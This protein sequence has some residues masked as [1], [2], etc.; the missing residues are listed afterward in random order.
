[1]DPIYEAMYSDETFFEDW[2]AAWAPTRNAIMQEAYD[3]YFLAAAEAAGIDMVATA[4]GHDYDNACD[5][6]CNNGCGTVREVPDHVYDDDT[7]LDCNE[8][9]AVRVFAWDI[10]V[11]TTGVYEIAP[12]N[13]YTADFNASDIIV[14]DEVGKAVKYNEAKGGYP[15]AVGVAY[16]VEFVNTDLLAN[17]DGELDWYINAVANQIFADVSAG[18]WYNEAVTYAVGA[19]IIT[20]YGG[21]NN[22]G[23]ADKITRHDFVVILARYAGVDLSVYDDVEITFNDVADDQYYTNAILWAAD[24][25]I[26]TGYAGGTK[27]GVGDVITR[28]QLVTFL[29]RYAKYANGGVA[30]EVSA[31]AAD[32]AAEYVDFAAVTDYA[33]EAVI[34]ALDN[35]VIK[36]QGGTHIAPA[37]NALRCEVAQIIYNLIG[38]L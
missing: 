25:G 16:T 6:E 12:N 4:I 34:W 11:D 17:I 3:Q 22:F 23:S 21:T 14:K 7:D 38:V 35:G 19:G 8:C 1:M 31:D 37:G 9:G 15:L 30:P 26:T 29:Y 18:A 28:E 33:K 27:F 5:A 20:G 32:K 2:E 24:V 10:S 36:G 13:A